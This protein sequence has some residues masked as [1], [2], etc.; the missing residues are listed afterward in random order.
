MVFIQKKLILIHKGIRGN[1]MDMESRFKAEMAAMRKRVGPT[2]YE[3]KHAEEMASMKKRVGPTSYEE[4]HRADMKKKNESIDIKES[5]MKLIDDILSGDSIEI[6]NT[7]QSIIGDKIAS[8]LEDFKQEVA[9]GMFTESVGGTYKKDQKTHWETAAKERG[10]TVKPTVDDE[11]ESGKSWKAV[12]KHGNHRGSFH[13]ERGG[14]LHESEELDE[15]KGK[16][17]YTPK[18]TK[19]AVMPK[20][21]KE[22]AKFFPLDKESEAK[23]HAEIT[24]GKLVKID[25]AGRVIKESEELD[26]EIKIGDHVHIGHMVKGGA[27]VSGK[28][29]K[30]EGN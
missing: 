19:F 8:K 17:G 13:I 5:T 2:S 27:G 3:A 18:H 14:K 21:R 12:D 24:G 6:E 28:V 23:S 30:I 25:Q 20:S 7:F 22:F 29:K 9:Q 26:E 1:S 16:L 15:A 4:K 10:L 11:G